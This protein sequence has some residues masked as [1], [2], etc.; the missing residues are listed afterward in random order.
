MPKPK[1]GRKG[2]QL[3]GVDFNVQPMKM[4]QQ[5]VWDWNGTLWDDA[6]LCTEINNN[7][8]RRRNLP[9]ISVDDYRDKLVF[10]ISDYYSRIGFD[11]EAETY[12]AL[13]R[14]YI[15]EYERLRFDCPLRAGAISLLDDLRE[16]QIPQAVLSAYEHN[17]LVEALTYYD[18]MDYFSDVIGLND[19]YAEGKVANGLKYIKQLNMDPGTVLFI[20]DTIHD[21]EVA[22]AMGVQC[23]LISGGHN[24]KVRLETCGVPVLD[25]LSEVQ[26]YIQN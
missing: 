2:R 26:R 6:V 19:I 9:L 10:P 24:S 17:A 15:G 22:Q 20:G 14:E 25:S 5:V 16:R 11:C 13:A 4:I 21:F 18:L 3:A 8:L 23:V 12:E 7:M 1:L